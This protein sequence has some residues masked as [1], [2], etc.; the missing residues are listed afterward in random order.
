MK[1]EPTLFGPRTLHQRDPPPESRPL[2]DR[3]DQAMASPVS[4]TSGRS[5][6]RFRST[7]W[8]AS[9]SGDVNR[10]GCPLGGRFAWPLLV[11]IGWKIPAPALVPSHRPSRILVFD[12]RSINLLR[13]S[14][15]EVGAYFDQ[16]VLFGMAYDPARQPKAGHPIVPEQATVDE[17]IESLVEH[18]KK[19]EEDMA[20]ME[21]E[22]EKLRL[23]SSKAVQTEDAAKHPTSALVDAVKKRPRST[24]DAQRGLASP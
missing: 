16:H 14:L 5:R 8:P 24:V 2:S 17:T 22:Y 13:H 23:H 20:K 12:R 4:S 3:R 10:N 11:R 15:R 21:E 19:S 18:R 1:D 7:I 9:N 6:S